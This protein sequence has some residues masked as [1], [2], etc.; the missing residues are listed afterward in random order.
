[1]A[2]PGG[3]AGYSERCWGLSACD[4]DLGYGAFCPQNDRGVIAPTAALSAM[5]YTPKESMIALRHFLVDLGGTIR[6]RHGFRD[7][8]NLSENWVAPG[9][10]A[11]DQ[12]PIVVMIE[13]HRSGLLW[14]LFMSCPEIQA[15]LRHLEFEV[16]SP[17]S[18]P[19][20]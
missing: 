9:N 17:R 8:F 2:N 19:P 11:I 6:G 5:P 15:G 16:C 18:A 10:L 1:L 7:S 4:G 13:N 12:G 14:D 3:F 20:P